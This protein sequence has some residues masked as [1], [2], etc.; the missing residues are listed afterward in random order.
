MVI[1]NHQ[2]LKVASVQKGN[3]GNKHLCRKCVE[4]KKCNSLISKLETLFLCVFLLFLQKPFFQSRKRS[5]AF[6]NLRCAN[7]SLSDTSKFFN[8]GMTTTTN[9]FN[10]RA[11][12]EYDSRIL[13]RQQ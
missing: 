4:K 8:G 13:K 1:V 10:K 9:L 5:W 12:Q 11:R 7:L 6:I 3:L 2:L